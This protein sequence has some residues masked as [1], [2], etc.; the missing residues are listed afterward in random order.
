MIEELQITNASAIRWR[1]EE[2]HQHYDYVTARAVAY[3]DVIL[4]QLI[5]LTKPW[6]KIILYKL[7]TTEEDELITKLAARHH[8][9]ILHRH[10]YT[11]PGDKDDIQRILYIF[12]K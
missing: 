7:L 8:L 4:P 3:S 9:E 6:G 2:H 1:A 10:I 12:G 5:R 11:L